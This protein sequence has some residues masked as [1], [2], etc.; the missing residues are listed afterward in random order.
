VLRITLLSQSELLTLR[1]EG[2]LNGPWVSELKRSW[3]G[4]HGEA[5]QRPV[6]V[7]LSEVTYVSPE[8]KMLLESMWRQGAK[9]QSCSLLTRFLLSQLRA[10][11]NER[12][13]QNGE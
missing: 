6:A 7:D 13:S 2:K 9:L 1:L 12:P 8:G 5:P 10:R 11:S 3:D 4:L